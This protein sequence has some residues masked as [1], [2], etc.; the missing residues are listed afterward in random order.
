MR[1]RDKA[2]PNL[3]L[4]LVIMVYIAFFTAMYFLFGEYL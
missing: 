4:V 1:F 2:H 3:V